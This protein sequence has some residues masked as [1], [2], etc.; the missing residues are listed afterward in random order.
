MPDI[1][2]HLIEVFSAGIRVVQVDQVQLTAVVEE[3][4]LKAPA[5]DILGKLEERL[6][7]TPRE[8]VVRRVTGGGLWNAV[9]SAAHDPH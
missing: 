5:A 4:I 7:L 6:G 1:E 3:N 2:T 9:L 8:A